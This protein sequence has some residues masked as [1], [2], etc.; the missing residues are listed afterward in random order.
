MYCVHRQ[1]IIKSHILKQKIHIFEKILVVNITYQSEPSWGNP[2]EPV[3]C[4]SRT[5]GGF[6]W[7]GICSSW[8]PGSPPCTLPVYN[9]NPAYHLS[10]KEISNR[11]TRKVHLIISC[12]IIA[13]KIMNKNLLARKFCEIHENL[14]TANISLSKLIIQ[15]SIMSSI[16]L[17]IFNVSFAKICCWNQFISS[18]LPK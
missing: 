4:H 15:C 12:T 9:S 8:S 13:L 5:Q 17:I 16:I 10:E 18:I 7:V 14:I 2:P 6:L 1:I 3:C 11:Y